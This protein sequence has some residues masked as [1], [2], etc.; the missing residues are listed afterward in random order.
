MAIRE[1]VEFEMINDILTSS[2]AVHRF[3]FR[4]VYFYSFL[5]REQ[6]IYLAA[7]KR[8]CHVKGRRRSLLLVS[9]QQAPKINSLTAPERKNKAALTRLC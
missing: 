3:F 6:G 9:S 8:V 5:G 1:R 2:L 4:H 7:G